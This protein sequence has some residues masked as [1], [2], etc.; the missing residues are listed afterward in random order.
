MMRE[1]AVGISQSP[2]RP[3]GPRFLSPSD[4]TGAQIGVFY[5]R[6]LIFETLRTSYDVTPGGDGT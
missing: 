1:I 2:V 4:R 6:V 5:F 3:N